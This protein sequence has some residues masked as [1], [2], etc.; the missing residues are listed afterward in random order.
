MSLVVLA[1]ACL[2]RYIRFFP[3]GNAIIITP[4]LPEKCAT[5]FA[6]ACA[7]ILRPRLTYRIL[8]ILPMATVTDAVEESLVGKTHAELSLETR[9]TF[10]KFAKPDEN[11][12]MYLGEEEFIDAIAP[13]EE[14]YVSHSQSPQPAADLLCDAG[15]SDAK[16][17]AV[18]G[19]STKSNANS[20]PSSSM[21]RIGEGPARSGSPTGP[22]LRTSCLKQTQST[23][24]LF[25]YSI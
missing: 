12:E 11:G 18:G 7:P 13:P 17:T 24:L 23:R 16:L 9:A 22:R 1:C 21:S 19:R 6:P 4:S 25:A 8:V 2:C 14:D 3:H 5:L 10:G 20:M 15:W